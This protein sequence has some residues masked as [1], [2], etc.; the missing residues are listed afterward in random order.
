MTQLQAQQAA[1]VAL[2]RRSDSAVFHAGSQVWVPIETVA[3][4]AP[5]GSKKKQRTWQRGVVEVSCFGRSVP[6]CCWAAVGLPLWYCSCAVRPQTNCCTC[7]PRPLGASW[8]GV[9]KSASSIPTGTNAL[10]VVHQQPTGELLLEVR[11]EQGQQLEGLPAADCCLQVC[12]TG[13]W[14]MHVAIVWD[15]SSWDGSSD[16]SHCQTMSRR[17][18]AMPPL[19]HS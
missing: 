19:L 9:C 10:Q 8:C 18:A 16:C 17:R 15:G 6:I 13:A 11:T 7:Q 14:R 12:G 3:G 5:D 2:A 4:L 1:L